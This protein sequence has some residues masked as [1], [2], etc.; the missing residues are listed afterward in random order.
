MFTE[1]QLQVLRA[2][3]PVTMLPQLP[4]WPGLL[5]PGDFSGGTSSAQAGT[6]PIFPAAGVSV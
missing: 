4:T 5:I 6:G 3:I 2:G 1:D